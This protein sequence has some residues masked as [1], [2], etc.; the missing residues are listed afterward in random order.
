MIKILENISNNIICNWKIKKMNVPKNNYYI[1]SISFF[2]RENNID[3]EKYYNGIKKI[4]YIFKHIYNILKFRLRIYY[5]NTTQSDLN[6]IL[7]N[8]SGSLLDQIE[9]YQY[10][11]PIFR[12]ENIKY[13]KGTIG[14]I[15]RL[16]PLYDYDLHKVDKCII[17]DIDNTFYKFYYDIINFFIKKNL[18]FC[19]RSRCCYGID[20]RFLCLNNYKIIKFPVIA[21]FIYQSISL[22][23]NIIMK[24][25][26]KL[27]F[28]NNFKYQSLITKCNIASKYEYGIDEFYLN[29][30]H[31]KYFYDNNIKIN[32][33]IYMYNDIKAGILQYIDIDDNSNFINK[34]FK[35][36]NINIENDIKHT[37]NKYENII[38][39]YN[40]NIIEFIK[41]ELHYSN[42]KLYSFF[43][44]CLLNNFLYV[45]S[46]HINILSINNNK[47]KIIN[48]IKI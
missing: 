43:L 9:L 46:K 17:F 48:S 19:Y 7:L 40:K 32:P 13:H 35:I 21:S 37:I 44:K 23:K 15:I 22:N 16:F 12:S 1:I 2:Y 31:I 27:Y 6:N 26:D 11:I 4:I 45:K 14:T 3:H 18:I 34:L 47:I 5:D 36:L 38:T 33:I 29:Y 20:Q 30:V 8:I 42:N 41:N 25:F 28:N 39:R 24:F 10:D